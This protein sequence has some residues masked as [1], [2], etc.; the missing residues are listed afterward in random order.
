MHRTPRH[1]SV[2]SELDLHAREFEPGN[3]QQDP[4][5]PPTRELL[6]ILLAWASF[7]ARMLL[8]FIPVVELLVIQLKPCLSS[9]PF[10]FVFK[11]TCFEHICMCICILSNHIKM[12]MHSRSPPRDLHRLPLYYPGIYILGFS[13]PLFCSLFFTLCPD[14]IENMMANC[15]NRNLTLT[16]HFNLST[17]SQATASLPDTL[18][19][20]IPPTIAV[21]T[22]RLCL[23]VHVSCTALM[24]MRFMLDMCLA[25]KQHWHHEEAPRLEWVRR[26]LIEERFCQNAYCM[27]HVTRLLYAMK[28]FNWFLEN[29]MY[30]TYFLLVLS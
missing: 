16:A 4:K 23:L 22:L 1:N 28:C 12:N 9:H 20:L 27:R 19:D 14:T 26:M 30:M 21:F 10:P 11:L 17:S 15:T 24:F 18:S 6:R 5:A 7:A 8:M 25:W 29:R 13:M 3:H 2:D